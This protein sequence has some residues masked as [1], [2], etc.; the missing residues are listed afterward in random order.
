[1]MKSAEEWMMNE[2]PEAEEGSRDSYETWIRRIQVDALKWA[3]EAVRDD[4]GEIAA[5]GAID[6][7]IARLLGWPT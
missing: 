2:A 3:A 1:M 5:A 6:A 4:R 7:Q